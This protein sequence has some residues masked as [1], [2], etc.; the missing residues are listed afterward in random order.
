MRYEH[1]LRFRFTSRG[2]RLARVVWGDLYTLR[3]L[4]S[5]DGRTGGVF[6]GRSLTTEDWAELV[7]LDDLVPA[8]EAHRLMGWFARTYRAGHCFNEA[9]QMKLQPGHRR[10]PAGDGRLARKHDREAGQLL[11]R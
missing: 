11:A 10:I 6:W 4:T 9:G 8:Q 5:N 7:C 3:M 2:R 1:A